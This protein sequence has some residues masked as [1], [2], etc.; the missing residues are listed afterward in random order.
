[1]YLEEIFDPIPPAYQSDKQD[2]SAIKITDTRKNRITL[3]RLN[4][5]RIM[6]DARKLEH[7]K[8]LEKVTT[9]YK[10]PAAAPPV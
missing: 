6:N 10:V 2:N 9:Q 7:E 8:K 5:L 3:H 1:M 4:Q